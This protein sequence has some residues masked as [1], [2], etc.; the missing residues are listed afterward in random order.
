MTRVLCCIALHLTELEMQLRSCQRRCH[1]AAD[2]ADT[3]HWHHCVKFDGASCVARPWLYDDSIVSI[4]FVTAT[5]LIRC[6][7]HIACQRH[8]VPLTPEVGSDCAHPMTFFALQQPPAG[9][10]PQVGCRFIVS[11]CCCPVLRIECGRSGAPGNTLCSLVPR[12]HYLEPKT[13]VSVET[14]ILLGWLERNFGYYCKICCSI[15][16]QC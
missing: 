6:S 13:T 15:L 3:S 9:A 12:L 11:S 5:T 1:A 7:M 2:P 10:Q 4:V 14:H 16:L 8:V